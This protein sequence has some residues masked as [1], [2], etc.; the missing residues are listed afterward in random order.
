MDKTERLAEF[1]TSSKKICVF[2]GAG[3]SCAS[4]IPDFRSADGLY[5][6]PSGTTYQPEEIISH[7]FFYAHTAEFYDFYRKK[8]IFRDAK[9][10]KAHLFFARLQD[11][12]GKEVSVVTQNIDGLHQKAGSKKIFELHGSVERNYC[13]DCHR[14]YTL[15]DILNGVDVP[16]CSACGGIVKP[17]VVLYEEPLDEDIV[18]GA[19][20]SIYNA[21]CVIVVGTSLTVYPAASFLRYYRGK[22]LVLINKQATSYDSVADLVF[23]EDIISVVERLERI[24]GI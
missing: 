21:D 14:F 3:I 12:P 16:K 17:D 8:M 18:S 23:N 24:L 7:S 2:T 1:I 20:D 9:P 5:N 10:N 22:K 19:I 15:D 13:T 11:V 6:Q 4:G